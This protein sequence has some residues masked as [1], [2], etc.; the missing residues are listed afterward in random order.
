M[1][2]GG[3]PVEV[4]R[5]AV[6][7]NGAWLVVEVARDI[8][9]RQQ[10]EQAMQQQAAQHGLL[11]RF[12][13]L[14]LENP[15]LCDLMTQA[16]LI[17]QQGLSIE[18]CRLL[19]AEPDGDV[20]TQV[21]G[22]GWDA[23]WLQEPFFDAGEE[24]QDRFVLGARESIVLADFEAQQRFQRSPILQAHGVRSAVEV[25]ICGAGGAYGVIGG[26]A[27]SPDRFAAESA[28][29]VQSVANTLAEPSS[30]AGLKKSS[31]TW[32]STTR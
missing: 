1:L 23:A 27:K 18:L 21:A 14:A 22:C 9:A 12:G 10:L 30:A 17:V 7:V 19:E 24:T 26:Y 16:A 20:L 5:R 32:P 11:A 2:N 25:L 4:R 29:F 3:V 31:P 15:P 6:Q 8:T 13:Q 28:H